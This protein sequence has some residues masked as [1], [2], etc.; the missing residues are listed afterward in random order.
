MMKDCRHPNIIAYYGSYLRRDKLWICMEYCGGGS[1]QDI[2]HSKHFISSVVRHAYERGM[3][4][5]SLPRP[6]RS[7][8][9]FFV[10]TVTGPLTEIQIAYMCRETL[11]GLAYLHGMG[12]MHR[13][14]KGAN[15][16]LTEAGDVKL[17]D[18]GVSAQITAT[19]NKRKSFI[20]TPYWM[21]PEVDVTAVT[22]CV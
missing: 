6:I 11:L 5:C 1:L 10:C 7:G 19:I 12:K 13:D 16:L 20:G 8:T 18:F 21:A 4:V 9:I 2:Y 17:A 15:I 14:I 3:D 22:N